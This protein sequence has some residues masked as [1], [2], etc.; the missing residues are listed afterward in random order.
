MPRFVVVL[1]GAAPP[2]ELRPLLDEAPVVAADGA[3]EHLRAWDRPPDVLVGDL[4]AVGEATLAWCREAGADVVTHP[5]AKRDVDGW[6]AVREALDRGADALVMAGTTGGRAD[7][8]L[9]NLQLMRRAAV[10]AGVPVRAV[11]PSA[12]VWIATPRLPVRLEA[13][14]GTT[15]SVLALSDEARGV[16]LEGFRWDLDD[17]TVTGWDPFGVSNEL[18]ADEARVEVEAGVLAVFLVREDAL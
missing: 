2:E 12:R 10:E 3:A 7:M 4:D 14:S 11:E 6:L 18:R 16:R 1:D 15:A 13:P 17:A 8:Q 5:E 9:A